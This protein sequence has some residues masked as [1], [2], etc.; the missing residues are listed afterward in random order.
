MF[1]PRI[2]LALLPLVLWACAAAPAV[3]TPSP[4]PSPDPASLGGRTFMSV[5][6]TRDGGAAQLV[7]GTQIRLS[8]NGDQLSASAGCNSMSGAYRLDGDRLLLANAGVTEMGCDAPRQAQDD[9]LFRTLGGQPTLALKGN[10]LTVTLDATVINFLDREVADPDLQLVGPLWTVES[11]ISGETVSSVPQGATATFK[12]G[13]DGTVDLQTGCNSG[14][15]KFATDGNTL[16]FIDTVTTDRACA[17]A[18]LEAA[19]VRLLSAA[20][21]DYEIDAQV[22]TLRAGDEGLQLRAAGAGG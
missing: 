3:S 21:V 6:V 19:V 4:T 10:E 9:W 11:I 22:L 12:F 20:A 8:F 15:G 16:R 1:R 17:G 5:D 7:P 14:G 13:A 2:S 18:A